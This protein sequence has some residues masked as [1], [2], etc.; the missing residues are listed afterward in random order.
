MKEEEYVT[1]GWTT[2][3]D[4][5]EE[6]C[7]NKSTLKT[8]M[9]AAELRSSKLTQNIIRW[10]NGRNRHMDASEYFSQSL[11]QLKKVQRIL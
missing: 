7:R 11:H 3:R 8:G 1:C 10:F 9:S 6:D 2:S 4:E 5:L